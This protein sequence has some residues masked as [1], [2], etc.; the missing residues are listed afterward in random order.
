MWHTH[1][2]G[3]GW[4]TLFWY[5][6]L[7]VG[8]DCYFALSHNTWHS[9][10]PDYQLAIWFA[11]SYKN[12]NQIYLHKPF[13]I[14]LLSVKLRQTDISAV[15]L[16]WPHWPCGAHDFTI[17]VGSFPVCCSTVIQCLSLR[18]DTCSNLLPVVGCWCGQMSLISLCVLWMFSYLPQL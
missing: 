3:A 1:S 11:A 6:A 13:A 18:P 7:T 10:F 14:I 8:G 4:E 12:P 16:S 5:W 2:S 15:Y 17:A 9:F